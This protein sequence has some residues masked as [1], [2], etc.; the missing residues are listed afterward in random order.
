ML[1]FF[2][3]ILLMP[4]HGRKCLPGAKDTYNGLATYLSQ[5]EQQQGL[6]TFSESLLHVIS[7]IVFSLSFL[8]FFSVFLSYLVLVPKNRITATFRSRGSAEERER[9]KRRWPRWASYCNCLE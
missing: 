3:I 4:F 7:S 2:F 1:F 5:P 6:H 9:E 8:F